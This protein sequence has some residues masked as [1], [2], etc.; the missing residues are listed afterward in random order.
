MTAWRWRAN[1]RRSWRNAP[2]AS[3]PAAA[4]SI[5]ASDVGRAGD[6]AHDQL[7]QRVG[8]GEQDLALV[9]EMPE[10]RPLGQPRARGDLGDGRLLEAALAVEL[11]RRLRE[12][13]GARP[14]PIGPS[15]DH[16]R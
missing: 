9:G 1:S 13:A 7:L 4:A 15:R 3:T 5:G 10:E 12:S 8:A 11:H 2:A 16:S 14:A 6:R